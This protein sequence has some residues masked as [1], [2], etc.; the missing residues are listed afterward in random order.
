MIACWKG[1]GGPSY[2]CDNWDVWAV[3]WSHVEEVGAQS[4]RKS[5]FINIAS[6][7]HLPRYTSLSSIF[8]SSTCEFS[9]SYEHFT[10]SAQPGDRPLH[11]HKGAIHFET[12]VVRCLVLVSLDR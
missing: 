7:F 1:L 3:S 8:F 10:P 6:S 12:S 11:D 5:T 2:V 4:T 9:I